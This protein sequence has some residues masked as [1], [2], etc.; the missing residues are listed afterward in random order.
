MKTTISQKSAIYGGASKSLIPFFGPKQHNINASGSKLYM[1]LKQN[2][3]CIYK[4]FFFKSALL[5]NQSASI[6]RK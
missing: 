1:N 5:S 2:N 4:I 3:F 6:V